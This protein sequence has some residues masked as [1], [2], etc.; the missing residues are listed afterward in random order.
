MHKHLQSEHAD[1]QEWQNDPDLYI[2]HLQDTSSQLAESKFAPESRSLLRD[3][4]IL[5]EESDVEGINPF[6][7]TT[8]TLDTQGI[9]SQ[10]MVSMATDLLG[11]VH[12]TLPQIDSLPLHG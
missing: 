8:E 6:S 2:K 9:L 5:K 1:I 4:S 7:M 12:Q 10:T 11:N 3:L